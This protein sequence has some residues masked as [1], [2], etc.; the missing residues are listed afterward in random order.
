MGVGA[1][2]AALGIG[3][4]APSTAQEESEE[5]YFRESASTLT[6]GNRFYEV[7]FDKSNGAITRIFDKRGGGVVSEGNADGSLWGLS[8]GAWP[9][10]WGT[11]WPE[12]YF[13]PTPQQ[14][15]E[16]DWS[17][18]AS[19][20]T[21]SLTYD[22]PASGGT[23]SVHVDITTGV[24]SYI[25]FAA[26]VENDSDSQIDWFEF[27]DHLAFN[28]NDV[29]HAM[30]PFAGGVLLQRSFFRKA[31]S[32]VRERYPSW[33]AMG[34][35][36]SLHTT[37]GDITIY[38]LH[39]TSEYWKATLGLGHTASGTVKRSYWRHAFALALASGSSAE[40]PTVRIRFGVDPLQAILAYR[41][42]NRIDEYRDL[43]QKV[44]DYY[45][46]VRR[47]PT[48]EPISGW[49]S[50]WRSQYSFINAPA[51]LHMTGFGSEGNY[52]LI[53][54]DFWPPADELG[55]AAGYLSMMAEQQRNGHLIIPFASLT[56]ANAESE[57]AR[58]LE[59]E[60]LSIFDIGAR[61]VDDE[62]LHFVFDVP[63]EGGGLD[64]VS[65]IRP[66]PSSMR[67]QTRLDKIMADLETARS[68]FIYEDG[69]A[70]PGWWYDAHPDAAS[71]LR[72]SHA[73][74]EHVKRYADRNLTGEG[75]YDRMSQYLVGG[76]Y[77]IMHYEEFEF[78]PWSDEDWTYFPAAAALFRD[79]ALLW[80][81]NL[82]GLQDEAWS[83]GH[84]TWSRLGLFRRHLALGQLFTMGL[85]YA[86]RP[87]AD[88]DPWLSV[89]TAFSHHVVG[90]FADDLL[91]D[92]QGDTRSK[93]VSVYETASVTANWSESSLA[94]DGHTLVPGGVI[95]TAH[96]GS[97]VGG[98]FESYN[99]RP[100][101][102][103]EHY[104]I[105][106]RKHNGII[107]R[108]PLGTDTPLNVKSLE[109][110]RGGTPVRVASF[111]RFDQLID[112]SAS[113]VLRDRVDIVYEGIVG[114]D[115]ARGNFEGSITL[116]KNTISNGIELVDPAA[117]SVVVLRDGR[118]ARGF[119]SRDEWMPLA[120][121]VA[122]SFV[123]PAQGNVHVEVEYFDEVPVG[124]GAGESLNLSYVSRDDPN[125]AEWWWDG[126]RLGD[127]TWKVI[128]FQL[129][130]AIFDGAQ[131][132]EGEAVDF[133]M[134]LAPGY[135]IGK[136]TVLN[137][138]ARERLTAAYYTI[139]DPTQG[140]TLPQGLH[141]RGWTDATQPIA[142]LDLDGL[143][144]I[145]AWDAEASS[146]LLYSP[147]IPARFNNID[148]LEQGRAYYVRARNGQTL[149]WPDAPYGGVGFHLQPG[150]NLVCWLGTP[151]KPLTD[152]IAPL[153]G[154][155]AEPL[156]SVQI[157]GKTYDVEES[158]SATEPLPYG[159]ALW[160]E[161]DAV[162]P[163]RWLQF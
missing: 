95:F 76:Y 32:F 31:Q 78:L 150:R 3:R 21:L 17:W 39:G 133:T 37:G 71:P 52:A 19:D 152:A 58:V 24:D 108:Q 59:Q 99:G 1:G 134:W 22:V 86:G 96:D 161:I 46:T 20:Q 33:E 6:L 142:D 11:T 65:I 89:V 41:E 70:S 88:A 68:D 16:F 43:G 107:V 83:T 97:V 157:D 4:G 73:W 25:D 12:T 53:N 155:K 29:E 140:E 51:L 93:S 122:E 9:Y 151:D 67:Y 123:P 153:R 7:D 63:I 2:L 48:I 5:P 120:F 56:A 146:W 131:R 44:G 112:M 92:W 105:E 125:A 137:P 98:V 147:D 104:L 45:E 111:D 13:R 81:H 117:R 109:S 159:Q 100:L 145:H 18:E 132:I 143:Q 158:R 91:V 144:A 85:H 136:V 79:K 66:S 94:I 72:Y 114:S 69:V 50:N 34:D 49:T 42:D 40:L 141:L 14:R 23:I 124:D 116:R 102:F 38:P 26:R 138:E 84:N 113:S 82:M 121:R 61:T 160:V 90:P 35:L 156:V 162:G 10:T 62:L 60:G 28:S 110:W 54:P 30:L 135:Y 8:R 36:V 148:K 106:Q 87:W 57:T 163:T 74:L 75:M 127:K 64:P 130:N 154:M 77:S 118:E 27:P 129:A 101:S 128:T 119:A 115:E 103:G 126:P 55:G 149:H 15:A 139:H 47:S 80:W